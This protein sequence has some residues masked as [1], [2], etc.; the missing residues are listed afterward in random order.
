MASAIRVDRSLVQ[1]FERELS[2]AAFFFRLDSRAPSPAPP[3]GRARQLEDIEKGK[4]APPRTPLNRLRKR[5]DMIRR[6][7]ERL[8]RH[9]GVERVEDAPDGPSSDEILA[10]LASATEG[11]AD[12]EDRIIAATAR[13]GR[14][15]E[16]LTAIEAAMEIKKRALVAIDDIDMVAAWSVDRLGRSLMD[17]L[18][19]LTEL[20]A[21][22]VDLYLHQQGLD[23]STPSGRAMFQMMGVFAEFE[24]AMIRER[25]M[26]GLARARA[27]GI[28]LGRRPL[29]KTAG[30]K[31]TVA[32]IRA[33]LAAKTGVRR[34][35]RDLGV[36]VGTVIRIRDNA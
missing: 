17:L 1:K 11:E 7:S 29:E 26:A 23:T 14:I 30:G 36:G 15:V 4:K 22:D 8:L 5:M 33:A 24:R 32:T 6:A 3:K 19:L 20:H 10:Y 16:I 2:A 18:G 31:K 34:I 13:I 35:A 28:S 27:D 25:V 9:L 12:G 21:K